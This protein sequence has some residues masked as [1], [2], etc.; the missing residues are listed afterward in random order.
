MNELHKIHGRPCV[1]AAFLASIALGGFACLQNHSTAA[2]EE[3][4][5]TA[6]APSF[7]ASADP[8]ELSMAAVVEYRMACAARA[9]GRCGEAHRIFAVLAASPKLNDAQRK[10]CR[11]EIRRD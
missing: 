2:V 10:F 3:P 5:R 7:S 8:V 11:N 9:G 4:R 1:Y 6:L